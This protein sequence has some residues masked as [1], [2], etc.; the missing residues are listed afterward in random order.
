MHDYLLELGVEEYPSRFIASTKDQLLRNFQKGMEEGGL[1]AEGFRL[2]STPRRFAL[3][4]YGISAQ[5]EE[6]WDLVRGPSKKVAY[7]ED[8]QPSPALLG[9]LKSKQVF[10]EDITI[11]KAGKEDYVFAKIKKEAIS[12]EKTLKKIAPEA[13]RKI[14]NP[15]SMRWGGKKLRFLRPI[16]WIVSLLDDQ[17]LDFDLEGIS[18]GRTSRGHRFLGQGPVDIPDVASY[19]KILEENYVILDEEKRRDSI[20]RGIN[21]LAR[22]H[23]GLPY[24]NEELLEEVTNIVEYPTVFLG[25]I[26][27]EYLKLPPEV[28]ITPMMDH[29]RYFPVV[30]DK[31]GLLPYFLSVRNGN[32]QGLENV[33]AGNRKVLVPRLEDAKFF[34]QQ[35][36]AHPLEDYVPKLKDLTFHE[37]L[38]SML[39]KTK[40]LEELSARLASILSISGDLQEKLRRAATLSKADLATQMVVEF[41]ELQGTMGRIYAQAGGEDESVAR[42]IEEH[43]YPRHSDGLLPQTT[44]GMVLSLADKFDSLAGLFAIGVNVTGSQDPFGLRRA[45]IGILDI[46]EK[47]SLSFRLP[48]IFREALLLYV[49]SKGLVFDYDEVIGRILDFFRARMR[50]RFIDRGIRYDITDAVLASDSEDLLGLW[51]QAQAISAY[52]EKDPKADL[53]TSFVRLDNLAKKAQDGD[54]DPLALKEEDKCILTLLDNQD[55]VEEAIQ[56]GHFDQALDKLGVWMETVNAYLDRTMIMVEEEDLRR[57]RLAML[58]DLDR[59]VKKILD[60]S[61]I[62][63]D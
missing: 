19:E 8:G 43:Y 50:R 36:L 62:V 4:C 6:E 46:V 57:N 7:R 44:A 52:L 29:Q 38:G 15:R 25:E 33:I 45:A 55:Q 60:P 14:S 10:L 27:A 41:T 56:V 16:R 54:L 32:D 22:E 30:D 42:A 23:A 28:V 39:D 51:E 18:L 59:L 26:P 34:Y 37:D 2:E 40:R 53:I 9:F 12:I 11:E 48:D 31:G 58:R 13:I 20:L 17:V 47:Y 3:F 49:D 63:R 1:S 61:V 21:R 5:A 35:D 24:K